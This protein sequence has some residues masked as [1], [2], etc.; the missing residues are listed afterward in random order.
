[1][2]SLLIAKFQ[3]IFINLNPDLPMIGCLLAPRWS[4]ACCS[5]FLTLALGFQKTSYMD[6]KVK[7]AQLQHQELLMKVAEEDQVEVPFSPECYIHQYF[8]S[9]FAPVRLFRFRT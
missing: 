2:V 3:I 6:V 4:I 5:R 8:A 1:M 9:Q 7:L